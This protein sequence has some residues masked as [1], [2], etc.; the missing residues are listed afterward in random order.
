MEAAR[1]ISTRIDR[2]SFL[3]MGGAF[4]GSLVG[5]SL[6]GCQPAPPAA[7][8]AKKELFN[9][10][11]GATVLFTDV[12]YLPWLVAEKLGYFA[13][14]GI[15]HELTEFK[16][17]A[18]TTRALG[19]GAV[20]YVATG[21]PPAV[22]SIVKGEPFKIISGGW[23]AATSTVW[24]VTKD[25]SIKSLKDMKGKKLSF[26]S[27]GAMTD[28]FTRLA[29]KKAGLSETEV[30]RV[31]VGSGADSWTAT[32]TGIV[33]VGWTTDIIAAKVVL[34][35]E[36]RVLFYSSDLVP[37]WEDVV[38]VTTEKF[39][40]ERPD[41]LKGFVKGYQ[42]GMEYTV[43]NRQEAAKV[44]QEYNSEMTP[45]LAYAVLKDVPKEAF[46]IKL[47]AEAI[48]LAEESMLD[49]GLVKEKPPW[50]KIID[51]QF[52]PESL[53]IDVSKLMA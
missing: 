36:A 5:L 12:I 28:F 40:K 41:V 53:R 49:M 25:S 33:D 34:Q 6:L 38:L 19:T 46:T 48:R 42:R 37:A 17:G 1:S 52:L 2:R 7:P 15:K 14:E 47:S 10:Q 29:V 13:E 11:A 16:G 45:E 27:A 30:T 23:A 51:Q 39:I 43:N 35:N 3:K 22:N 24:V 31:P 18:D 20:N 26:S 21:I 32:K 50:D 44:L 8:K 9:S 4:G